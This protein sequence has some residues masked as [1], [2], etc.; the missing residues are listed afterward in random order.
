MKYNVQLVEEDV[1][2]KNYNK[3]KFDNQYHQNPDDPSYI[4]IELQPL[5]WWLTK[6]KGTKI[7]SRISL[8]SVSTFSDMRYQSSFSI[9]LAGY[10]YIPLSVILR[11]D[12]SSYFFD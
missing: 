1:T 6:I 7:K 3:I 12:I 10:A 8:W 2:K 5:A 4:L 11:V 9:W